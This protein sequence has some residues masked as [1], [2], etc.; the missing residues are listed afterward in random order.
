MNKVQVFIRHLRVFLGYCLA[1]GI[2]GSISHYVNITRADDAQRHESVMTKRLQQANSGDFVIMKNGEVFRIQ[3]VNSEFIQEGRHFAITYD[4]RMTSGGY[5][6]KPLGEIAR[7][8]T[9]IVN[10]MDVTNYYII[11]KC[12]YDGKYVTTQGAERLTC[13][14]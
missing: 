12:F 14:N 1:G 7:E 13:G 6:R 5:F 10:P 2:V 8:A 3:E 11:D 4:L 9:D